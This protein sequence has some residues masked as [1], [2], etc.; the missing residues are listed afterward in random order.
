MKDSYD[1]FCNNILCEK[2]NDCERG[3][4]AIPIDGTPVVCADLM[5]TEFCKKDEIS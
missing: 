1:V 3:A 4:Y 5:D 2:F